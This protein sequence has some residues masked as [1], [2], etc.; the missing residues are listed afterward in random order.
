M[1]RLSIKVLT[2]AVL[3][4]ASFN[5]V[6]QFH[7]MHREAVEREELFE[8]SG[9]I[10]CKFGPSVDEASRLYIQFSLILAFVGS[11]LKDFKHTLLSVVGLTGV[12]IFYVF[13]WQHYFWL[14]EVLGSEFAFVRHVA[15][16]CGANYLDILIAASV[17]LLIL[18]HLRLALLSIFRPSSA[19]S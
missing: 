7:R 14:A 5:L 10:I 16:L 11:W 8:Q 4:A 13:W 1:S 12:T 3:L 6:A 18:L 9:M 2:A 17:A 19:C 15:Y